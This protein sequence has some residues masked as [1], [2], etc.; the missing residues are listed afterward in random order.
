MRRRLDHAPCVAR[1]AHAAP[2]AG[3][4]HQKIMAASIATGAGEAIR[5][6]TAFEVFTKR[7]LDIRRWRVQITLSIKLSARSKREPGFEMI[8]NGAIKQA[9]LW[10]TGL[11]QRRSLFGRGLILCA[12]GLMRNRVLRMARR[13]R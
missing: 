3:K 5:K 13:S 7:S 12:M 11:I 2:F 6:D 1:W 4:R 10:M 9:L 8:R